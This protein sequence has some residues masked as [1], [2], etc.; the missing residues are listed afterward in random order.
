MPSV[1]D[2]SVLGINMKFYYLPEEYRIIHSTCFELVRQIEEFIVK[3]EYK[4]LRV[5]TSA[6]TPEELTLLEECSDIWDFLKKY[7]EE[8]FYTQLNKSLILGLLMDFCYFMQESLD[9][10]NKMRLVVSYAL[11]RR[12]LVDNLRILLRILADDSFYDN[13]VERDDYNPAKMDEEE[14]KAFL[15]ATDEIRFT[16]PITGEFIYECIY[17]QSNPG[18]LINLSNRAIH[19]VTTRKKNKTGAM[20]CNFMFVTSSDIDGLW[21]HYYAYLPAI[22]VFYS[23]LFNYAVFSLFKDEVEIN[24]FTKRLEKLAKTMTKAYPKRDGWN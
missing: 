5:S 8:Q 14:T 1:L 16:K 7:R 2:E 6:M 24:L 4:F 13:F 18:S 10:S 20:N 9:C 3:D 21:K 22:L 23:E 12:P 11:L 19:P 15:N 17:D